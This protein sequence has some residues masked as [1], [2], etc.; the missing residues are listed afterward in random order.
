MTETKF[1]YTLTPKQVY[2]TRD[3][4]NP[5]IEALTIGV[6]NDT[7]QDIVCQGIQFAL[8]IGDGET[9]LTADPGTIQPS[10]NQKDWNI[11]KVADGKYRALP[12]PPNTGIKAKS[13]VTFGLA[14]IIVNKKLG[15][16]A[17]EIT[18]HD[19][20][21]NPKT[22]IHINKIRSKL[23]IDSFQGNP[24][25]I[26]PGDTTTLS[27]VTTAAARVTLIPG[28]Y[29]NLKTTGN[30]DVKPVQTTTYTLTAFGEGPAVRLQTTV[31]V[32]SVKIDSF[33]PPSATIN[34][35]DKVTLS[36]KTQYAKSVVINPGNYIEKVSGTL[37][38]YPENDTTYIL[39]ATGYDGTTQNGNSY[40]KINPVKID[41]FKA[42]PDYGV[43]FGDNVTLSWKT[44]SATSCSISPFGNVQKN[45]S[46]DINP[47][48]TTSY[49]L[50]AQGKNGPRYKTVTVI[51]LKPGWNETTKQCP[52]NSQ[53]RPLVLG[54]KEKQRLFAM[55]DGTTRSVYSSDDGAAW[56]A[57]TL[58][59]GW[60][61]RS[62]CG[63]CV[64][65]D[66]LWLM[67]GKNSHYLNDVWN[68]EDG[69]TW[70]SVTGKADWPARADFGCVVF[71]NAIW[72]AGGIGE[73]GT[74]FNDLWSSSDGKT[75]T[76]ETKG[77]PWV[78]RS[79]F[80]LVTFN[81]L[82][83]VLAGARNGKQ[84]LPLADA[85]CSANGKVWNPVDVPWSARSYPH[86]AAI[87]DALYLAGGVNASGDR[88]WNLYQMDRDKQWNLNPIQPFPKID[89]TSSTE[90]Q[91][92]MWFIG[93]RLTGG[94][95]NKSVWYYVP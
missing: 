61:G 23:N 71:N 8:A 53:T 80:A 68:S 72:I 70:I 69:K 2:I 73:N 12:E 78:P 47:A 66:K 63:G 65:Q 18:E 50:T 79:A 57:V 48:V 28:K 74:A 5:S 82:L 6:S 15:T 91:D 39:T 32:Y 17:L 29:E 37:D 67:G 26:G 87:K 1:N 89:Y 81:N 27:W 20:D 84:S 31:T 93:G 49:Q 94:F 14:Q 92:A 10:S 3:D 4:Y 35:G 19:E 55:A 41:S 33:E 16:T 24:A 38:V 21:D 13:S 62:G 52:L 25:E 54:F 95:P 11:S 46:M 22:S 40:I 76:Q 77:T 58:E 9:D 56:N 45:G 34:A 64:F 85:W 86:V 44:E 30:V 75:W 88:V 43:R 51:P 83:W 59:A 90:Y 42:D 36:W 60:T 7:D